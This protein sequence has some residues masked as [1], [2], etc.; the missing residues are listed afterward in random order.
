MLQNSILVFQPRHF[1]AV[2]DVHEHEISSGKFR[3]KFY[4][5]FLHDFKE[6]TAIN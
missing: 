6:R 2:R 4:I 1:D 3:D 5:S